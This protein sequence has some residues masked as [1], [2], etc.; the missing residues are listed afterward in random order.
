[1]KVFYSRLYRGEMPVRDSY[2]DARVLR[3]TSDVRCPHCGK[4]MR[5]ASEQHP[6]RWLRQRKNKRVVFEL[7]PVE[8][9]KVADYVKKWT[10]RIQRKG[11][12][13]VVWRDDVDVIMVGLAAM[14]FKN[15]RYP[16][17]SASATSRPASWASAFE[18]GLDRGNH[19]DIRPGWPKFL[20]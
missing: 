16:S 8:P 17:K 14:S 12:L 6:R 18:P 13:Y 5:E 3:L 9:E 4:I 19:G 11:L 10:A 2:K 15:G 1:M 7:W 20:R